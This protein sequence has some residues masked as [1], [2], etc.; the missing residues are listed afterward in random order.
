MDSIRMF[1]FQRH[2]DGH[3]S[4]LRAK[5]NKMYKKKQIFRMNGIFASFRSKSI[6]NNV[7]TLSTENLKFGYF[8]TRVIDEVVKNET[9][10]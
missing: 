6:T 5:G 3:H 2:Y 4:I 8:P 1:S 9:R 7:A 10:R